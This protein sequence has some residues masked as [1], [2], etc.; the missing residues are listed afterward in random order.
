[1]AG[2]NGLLFSPADE[3]LWHITDRKGPDIGHGRLDDFGL[4]DFTDLGLPSAPPALIEVS[5]DP[6]RPQPRFDRRLNDGMTTVIGRLRED[7]V[8]ENGV[9]FVLLTHNTKMGAAKGAV[10]T[11]EYL[12]S[13]GLL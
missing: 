4:R 10:L 8:L 6:Y 1:M 11:A 13:T 2:A 12:A 5:D 3:T 7:P 9:K